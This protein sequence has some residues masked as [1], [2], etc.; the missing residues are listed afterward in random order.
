MYDGYNVVLVLDGK[1][2]NATTKKYRW[3]L[4]L[5]GLSGNATS[6]GVVVQASLPAAGIH[7]AGGIGGLLAVCETQGT[8]STSDDAG[9]WYLYDANGNVG[10]SLATTKDTQ[11]SIAG[12]ASTPA[13]RYEYDPYGNVTGPDPDGDGDWQEHATAYALANPIRFSTR[14]FDPETGLGQWPRRYYVPRLGRW[15]SRDPIGEDGGLNL[16][17]FGRNRAPQAIDALRAHPK[18]C[19]DGQLVAK[20]RLCRRVSG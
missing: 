17:A 3:G 4:D 14:W 18:T 2:S 8:P 9:Y 10:Q 20:S 12:A 15:T 6:A 11:G 19:E 7:G 16:Y 5:S 13:A 1:N